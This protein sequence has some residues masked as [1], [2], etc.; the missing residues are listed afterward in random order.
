MNQF[1]ID[2]TASRSGMAAAYPAT[3]D[4]RLAM[5]VR[6]GMVRSSWPFLVNAG[7]PAGA[8]DK[9]GSQEN[10]AGSSGFAS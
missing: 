3:S 4:S 1:V 8:G 9:Q 7:T 10:A 5:G 2:M 6:N